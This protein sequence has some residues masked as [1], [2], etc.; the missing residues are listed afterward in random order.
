MVYDWDYAS[1]ARYRAAFASGLLISLGLTGSAIV[2][3]T[4]LGVLLGIAARSPVLPIR[5]AVQLSMDMIRSLPAIVL[6]LLIYY[7][8]PVLLGLRTTDPFWVAVAALS[9]HLAAYLADV[10]RGA[11]AR[12][13][14]PLIEAALTVGFTRPQVLW[15]FTIPEAARI[16]LPTYALL[17]ISTLKLSSLA[18]VIAVVELTHTANLVIT[19]TFR[20]PEVYSVV[21]AVYISL[22]LPFSYLVRRLEEGR[23]QTEP[24]A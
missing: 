15:R 1:L 21:A 23:N 8:P 14:R 3:G 13:P 2:V 24:E 11:I 6:I 5:W 19:D 9:I 12:T 7:I 16:A 10:I 18:S 22:V 20:S 17:C 4:P